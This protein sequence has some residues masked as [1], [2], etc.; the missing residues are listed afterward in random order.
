METILKA[1][2]R[3]NTASINNS[4]NSHEDSLNPIHS[5]I[6]NSN[7]ISNYSS[8]TLGNSTTI[9]TATGAT[10]SGSSGDNTLLTTTTEIGVNS[11]N[12]PK[13]V[14]PNIAGNNSISASAGNNTITPLLTPPTEFTGY[15]KKKSPSEVKGFQS[16]YFILRSPGELAYYTQVGNYYRYYSLD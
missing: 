11:P 3:N 5:Y 16:R 6:N 12:S 8:T 1:C 2:A 15:L 7:N 4:S 10:G 9:I 13:S 14:V